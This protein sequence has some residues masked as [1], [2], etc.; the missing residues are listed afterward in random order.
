MR[1]KQFIV[2]GKKFSIKDH[3]A[4]FKDMF[5][6]FLPVAME[7][8]ELDSLPEMKFSAHIHDTEQPTFGK[9][10]DGSHKL[11]VALMNRHP[12]DILRTVAHELVHYKQDTNHELVAD[13]GA[14]GSPHENQANALAG[15]VMRNFNKK[16]PE[17]LSSK[18]ITEGAEHDPENLFPDPE[19]TERHAQR[20][21]NLMHPKKSDKPYRGKIINKIFVGSTGNVVPP[22]MKKFVN[23]HVK[24]TKDGRSVVY[25]YDPEFYRRTKLGSFQDVWN[26][27]KPYYSDAPRARWTK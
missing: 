12:N 3:G 18:P 4:V 1:A 24:T 23:T 27:L 7:E 2:E 22:E 26:K 14:T 20:V 16:Y 13:S 25:Q 6:K 5:E 17:F 15:V 19:E 9:Y 10:E 8:I 11:Y 21:L